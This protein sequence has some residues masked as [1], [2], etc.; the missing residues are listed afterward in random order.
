LSVVLNS[1]S[2][3]FMLPK[4]SALASI[5]LPASTTLHLS[6]GHGGLFHAVTGMQKGLLSFPFL[7][8]SPHIL[9]Y[10]LSMS[11]LHLFFFCYPLA[12][13]AFR[14]PTTLATCESCST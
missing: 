7:S 11:S 13:L 2:L 6:T 4:E 14:A 5:P 3:Y 9:I 1:S 10:A 12:L 8:N